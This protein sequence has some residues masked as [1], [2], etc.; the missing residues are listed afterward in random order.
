MQGVSSMKCGYCGANNSE[1]ARFCLNC[2][3]PMLNTKSNTF[4]VYDAYDSD[5]V[6]GGKT[7]RER[8]DKLFI[9]DKKSSKT[10]TLGFLGWC[11]TVILLFVPYVNFVSL[12]LWAVFSKYKE[13]KYLSRSLLIFVLFIGLTHPLWGDDSNSTVGT[14]GTNKET[15]TASSDNSN[16]LTN[17]EANNKIPLFSVSVGLDYRSSIPE[18]ESELPDYLFKEYTT[19]VSYTDSLESIG[20]SISQGYL[21]Y[22]ES[23]NDISMYLDFLEGDLDALRSIDKEGLRIKNNI[24][25]LDQLI[26]TY[27]QVI[28]D[29]RYILKSQDTTIL[30]NYGNRIDQ[31][32]LSIEK[33]LKDI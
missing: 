11:V 28:I 22:R 5:A 19:L 33:I 4:K 27:E 32:L 12:L 25:L 29:T 30:Y 31:K 21:T 18:T 23:V 10:K 15:N 8:A 1:Y 13:R 17:K 2:S 7:K 3:T 6:T 14:L 24:I 16:T 9:S 26:L 20:S